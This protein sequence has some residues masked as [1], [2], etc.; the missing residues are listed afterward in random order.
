MSEPTTSA[1]TLRRIAALVLVV[2]L[3]NSMVHGIV[4][5]LIPVHVPTRTQAL[6]L[7]V[8]FVCPLAGYALLWR[9]RLRAGAA[10]YGG[11]FAAA[12]LFSASH[13]FLL[14]NPDHIA[15]IPTHPLHTHF[16]A[17]AVIEV[18]TETAGAVVGAVLAL[19]KR[20]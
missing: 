15:A 12:A 4:H 17:S 7:F 18:G 13:H 5:Q 19:A 3:I 9:G 1:T 14:S 6:A 16:E 10:V 8:V 2:H 11:A 20:H